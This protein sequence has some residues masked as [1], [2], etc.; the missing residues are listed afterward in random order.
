MSPFGNACNNRTSFFNTSLS[1][2]TSGEL[3]GVCHLDLSGEINWQ[4]YSYWH[5]T[6]SGTTVTT[7]KVSEAYVPHMAMFFF[8][9]CSYRRLIEQ[10]RGR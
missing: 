2:T 6:S 5:Y 1:N 7:F 3:L 9:S 8:A 10:Y 4:N